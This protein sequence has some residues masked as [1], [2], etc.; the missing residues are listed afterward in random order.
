MTKSTEE[1]VNV[2]DML[3]KEKLDNPSCKTNGGFLR[4]K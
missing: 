2:D 4:K 1:W 3:E